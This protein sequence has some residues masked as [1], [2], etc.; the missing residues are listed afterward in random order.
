MLFF[1]VKR[2]STKFVPIDS[3][4]TSD[5][6]NAQK[7]LD[8]YELRG[9]APETDYQLRMRVCNQ[10]GCSNYSSSDFVFHTLD[11]M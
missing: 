2:N 11:G 7:P 10:L 6:K 3:D 1:Q 5:L 9:L 8:Y 4:W